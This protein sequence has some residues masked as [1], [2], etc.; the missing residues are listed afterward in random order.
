MEKRYLGDSVYAE[1]KDGVII[2]TTENGMPDDPSNTII[3][4]REVAR[5]YDKFLENLVEEMSVKIIEIAINALTLDV[6]NCN[7]PDCPIHGK[8]KVN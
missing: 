6:P 2:L 5:A 4:N 8:G 3:I 7:N 1:F